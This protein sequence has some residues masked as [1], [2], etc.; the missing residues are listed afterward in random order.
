[1]GLLLQPVEQVGY[2]ERE[3]VSVMFARIGE[4]AL[5]DG[6]AERVVERHAGLAQE[7]AEA[8]NEGIA[9]ENGGKL[10]MR[11]EASGAREGFEK[12]GVVTRDAALAARARRRRLGGVARRLGNGARRLGKGG[13]GRGRCGDRLGVQLGAP[14]LGLGDARGSLRIRVEARAREQF[15]DLVAAGAKPRGFLGDLRR[16]RAPADVPVDP[17]FRRVARTQHLRGDLARALGG[18]Q[19][20]LENVPKLAVEPSAID[21]IEPGAEVVTLQRLEGRLARNTVMRGGRNERGGMEL[22]IDAARRGAREQGEHALEALGEGGTIGADEGA[23]LAEA[24]GA[25]GAV[26]RVVSGDRGLERGDGAG[27]GG[28]LRVVQVQHDRS[29]LSMNGGAAPSPGVVKPWRFAERPGRALA[30]GSRARHACPRGREARKADRRA[31]RAFLSSRAACI[32]F[33][34]SAAPSRSA[35]SSSA[36][37]VTR[38]QTRRL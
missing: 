27:F 3:G 22:A 38:A 24:L 20:A 37:F 23:R 32:A 16:R 36:D 2:V 13:R 6:I 9:V 29:S 33:S 35:L 28:R 26:L 30:E 11:A 10:G 15:L 1:M 34:A 25:S 18:G 8:G 21:R 12:A 19:I 7:P 31:A 14:G 5:L 4:I 17:A